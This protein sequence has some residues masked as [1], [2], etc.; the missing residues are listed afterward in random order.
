MNSGFKNKK[1]LF[2]D[3]N[4]SI[5]SKKNDIV[6]LAIQKKIKVKIIVF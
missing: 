6:I 3:N 1:K 2:A 4:L 5:Q